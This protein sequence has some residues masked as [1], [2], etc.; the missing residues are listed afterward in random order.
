MKT[1]NYNFTLIIFSLTLCFSSQSCSVKIT[2]EQRLE[3]HSNNYR[4]YKIE[5][6]ENGKI[7]EK[8]IFPLK[9]DSLDLNQLKI[10]NQFFAKLNSSFPGQK[11]FIF[12][13]YY[14]GKDIC[15]STGNATRNS[16][17]KG[18]KRFQN[19][20]QKK[21]NITTEYIYKS[22]EGIHRHN[23]GIDWKLDE[24]QTIENT[25]FTYHYPCSSYVIL[26]KSGKYHAYFGESSIAS[27]LN[28]IDLFIELTESNTN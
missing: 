23:K 4:P 7:V 18:T 9:I 21:N 19:A 13:K 6:A 15:N 16:I 3:N 17:G 20:I 10:I 2:D 8:S 11:D 1:I 22:I 27:Q 14:P 5:V 24:K 26:H 28:N 12:I 25:F